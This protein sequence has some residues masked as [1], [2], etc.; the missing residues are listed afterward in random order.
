MA[1]KIPALNKSNFVG[2][3]DRMDN[4]LVL[5]F[6]IGTKANSLKKNPVKTR[7]IPL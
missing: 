6:Y 4:P 1:E 3:L 2:V 7:L 5:L